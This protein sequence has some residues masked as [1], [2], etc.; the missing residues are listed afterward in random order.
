MQF[1][2]TQKRASV[3]C[4]ITAVIVLALWLLGP[5]LTP[6]VVAAVLAYA[7]SPLVNRIDAWGRGRMPRVVAVILVELL[8]ILILLS[9]VLLIIP[10]V[11]K[12]LPL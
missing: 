10:I 11:A 6:F 2:N 3:W 7:L 8:F 5:V 4:L 12:E 9:L 1:T